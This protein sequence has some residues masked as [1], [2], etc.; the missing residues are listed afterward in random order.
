MHP[1]SRL[2]LETHVAS[3]R[4]KELSIGFRVLS[5]ET[6]RIEDLSNEAMK[7]IRDDILSVQSDQLEIVY[8]VAMFDMEAIDATNS[9]SILQGYGFGPYFNL[10]AVQE[11][12]ATENGRQAELIRILNKEN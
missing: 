2:R 8:C 11:E 7:F 4:L 6:A 9:L 5:T 3:I 12:A 1:I 10:A